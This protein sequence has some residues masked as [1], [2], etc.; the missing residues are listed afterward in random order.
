[1]FRELQINFMKLNEMNAVTKL[2]SDSREAAMRKLSG[3]VN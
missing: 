1:M 2:D 3:L